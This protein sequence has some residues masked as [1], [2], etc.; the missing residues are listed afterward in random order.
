MNIKVTLDK[1][2]KWL[3]KRR[4]L[5]DP[6]GW[7]RDIDAFYVLGMSGGKSVDVMFCKA[8]FVERYYKL[9]RYFKQ[10]KK[11]IYT[12]GKMIITICGIKYQVGNYEEV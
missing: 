10:R 4:K 1:S 5:T 2:D 12:D 8:A 6:D 3:D 7:E 9:I 11:V